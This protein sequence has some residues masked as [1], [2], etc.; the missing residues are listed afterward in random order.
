MP[1]YQSPF[2]GQQVDSAI[3]ACISGSIV[4][5][6]NAYTDAAISSAIA[7]GGVVDPVSK[8]ICTVPE[9]LVVEDPWY[10]SIELAASSSFSPVYSKN[11]HD[12]SA[13]ACCL[14]F[15]GTT[16]GALVNGRAD[17]QYA[18]MPVVVD[19]KSVFGASAFESAVISGGGYI[20]YQWIDMDYMAVTDYQGTV[21]NAA[22]PAANPAG[23]AAN[24][25]SSVA[26]E[27][28]QLTTLIDENSTTVVLDNLYGG[29]I[30]TYE[31]P[32]SS[33]VVSSAT[34]NSVGDVVHFIAASGGI[35]IDLPPG[36]MV[37]VADD[38]TSGASYDLMVCDD[39]V[40]IKEI[41]SVTE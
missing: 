5:S 19:V 13:T 34:S 38:I 8:F 14:A 18:G 40:A 15:N 26:T 23:M 36:L 9:D 29:V 24:V 39:R 32:V 17:Y 11:L 27:A 31:T 12:D 20:R 7:S 25:I 21:L 2:T 37:L 28:T 30:Y 6:A 1:G 3:S 35:T 22:P 10:L 33:I 41:A 4:S 16:F